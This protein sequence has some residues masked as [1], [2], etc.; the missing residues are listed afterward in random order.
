MKGLRTPMRRDATR[1][2]TEARR[3]VAPVKIACSVLMLLIM[4]GCS[5]GGPT[6]SRTAASG[7]LPDDFRSVDND[8]G[9]DFFEQFKNPMPDDEEFFPIAVWHESL[10][11]PKDVAQD[12]SA[13]INTYVELTPDSDV[14]LAIDRG[15]F[16]LSGSASDL[17]SG[18][19][20]PDEVDMWGKAG[21]GSWTGE[22]PGEGPICSPES[23]GCGYTV[24]KETLESVP[25]GTMTYANFGKGLT[26]W[27]DTDV[28]TDFT[29]NFADVIS[30]DNY[31]FTDPNICSE[32][33]GGTMFENPVSLPPDEC[34]LAANYG[35]TVR[36][37]RSLVEPAG[38]KPVWGFVELAHPFTD[39]KAPTIALPEIRAAV[40]NSIIAG[41][42]GIV[43]FN[44]SFAGPCASQ[45]VLR[46]CGAELRE[47]VAEINKKVKELA[48]II[49]APSAEGLLQINGNVEARVKI[50]A[51]DIYVMA[52]SSQAEG[53]RV[54]F[55]LECLASKQGEVVGEE[56]TVVS[57]PKGFTDDFANGN[58]VHIYR[59]SGNGCGL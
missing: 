37:V 1:P 4:V 3:M 50:H 34:R 15:L 53:Q 18:R 51:G 56:R 46:D 12:K 5:N 16:A 43:Y 38:S 52:A 26:F 30:A 48:P 23:S 20:L 42:R 32:T 49:N 33:E 27:T 22:W 40:W 19:V 36:K 39:E 41:A 2:P 28:G 47:G 31:W 55:V 45:H 57:G 17:A 9:N 58:S 44:H 8:G 21:D 7:P 6:D 25:E 29:S 11:D 59:F 14:Q 24:L 10:R 35:W 54:T 13:G